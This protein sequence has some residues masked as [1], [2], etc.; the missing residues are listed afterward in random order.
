MNPLQ[1]KDI[2][3]LSEYEAVRNSFR[4]RIIALKKRRRVLLGDRLTLVFENRDTILFQIQEMMRVEHIY[5]PA[6]IQDEL[7]TYNPLIAGPDELSSTLFIE[8]TEPA[9]IKEILDQLRGID[10]GHCV[11]FE[12]GADRVTG[13]FEEGHSNE[14]KLSAVHY[15]RFRFSPEQRASFRDDQVPAALIVD[16][17]HYRA[18][19]LLDKDVRHELSGD[20]L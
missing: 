8:I 11:F 20:F 17:P 18:R 5:D 6:K 14:E 16:H 10:S 3:P 7:D 15:V 19:T 1:L 9:R 12:L 4:E 13:R 2:K